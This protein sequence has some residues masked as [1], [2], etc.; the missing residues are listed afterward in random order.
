M[1]P[2][3]LYSVDERQLSAYPDSV[4]MLVE[5]FENDNYNDPM[6][7]ADLFNQIGIPD[8]QKAFMIVRSDNVGSRKS[9][10]DY[11]LPLGDQS[12]LGKCDYLDT[13]AIFDD[14]IRIK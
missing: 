8:S 10:A 3:Y 2:W 14:E 9:V 4:S 12:F 7:A 1:S 11:L 6:I 5:V 13:L